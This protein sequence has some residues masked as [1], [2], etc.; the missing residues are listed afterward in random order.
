MRRRLIQLSLFLLLGA[1][2]N[3][4]V[5]W[6]LAITVHANNIN[7]QQQ[8]W[9]MR[10]A[11][12]PAARTY[13]TCT[14]W[15]VREFSKPGSSLVVIT[16]VSSPHITDLRFDDLLPPVTGIRQDISNFEARAA[17]S[18]HPGFLYWDGRGWPFISMACHW[19]WFQQ[20]TIPDP[21]IASGIA[22]SS[23]SARNAWPYE[24]HELHA[25]PLRAVWPGF[26]INTLFY[27][28]ILWLL[29]AAPFALRRRIR[30]RRGMCPA[31]AYPVGDSDVCT[32]CGRPLIKH[33]SR[34]A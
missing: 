25:L 19:P 13:K 24:V 2:A 33:K 17:E 21:P 15:H 23:P 30:V 29:F 9:R 14:H 1:I 5:A 11:V 6:S 31:C 22:L 8:G 7:P 4:A 18:D 27:A 12:Q 26:A 32:E 10:Q 3:V 28:V 16:C 34:N 20:I